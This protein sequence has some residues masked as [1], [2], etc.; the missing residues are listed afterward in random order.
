LERDMS[1]D[2]LMMF[3]WSTFLLAAVGASVHLYRHIGVIVASQA[4]VMTITALIDAMMLKHGFNPMTSL[5]VAVSTG[6]ALGLI[7]LPVLLQ[8]G[9][10]LLLILTALSQLVMVEAW[11]A[12]PQITGGS[13][14]ILL[15][16]KTD[17]GSAMMVF[18]MLLAGASVYLHYSVAQSSK[19]FD[20]ACLKVLG[21]KAGA[22][23]VP[24]QRLY[25]IGFAIYGALLGAAGVAATRLLGYLTVNSFGL[26]WSLATVMIVL[27]W[28]QR[29]IFGALVLTILYSVIR[30]LLRHSVY[31]SVGWSHAFEILFP[32]ILFILVRFHLYSHEKQDNIHKSHT[33]INLHEVR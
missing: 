15:P 8:T 20:W 12:L 27:S 5:L 6:I 19:R 33:K 1:I 22:F 7:H 26:T 17:A 23:G 29:P 18:L 31:A 14:G 28:P 11:Y 2:L 32:L 3:A 24:S 30:V 4:S 9:P 10:G 16:G 25:V 21:T 13:G